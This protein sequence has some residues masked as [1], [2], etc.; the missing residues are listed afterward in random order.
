[1][2]GADRGYLVEKKQW[3]THD[4]MM[5][6]TVIAES[7]RLPLAV[8]GATYV[9]YNQ[10][11]LPGAAVATVGVLPSFCISFPISMFL[12]SFPEISWGAHAF[13]G[14]RVAVG[15]LMSPCCA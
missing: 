13:L 8:N 10:K 6:L 2:I 3:I 5:D 1:M 12:N 7:T 14:I 9:G 11:G 15:I 4:E